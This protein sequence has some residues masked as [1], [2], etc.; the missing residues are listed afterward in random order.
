MTKGYYYGY[1]WSTGT[2]KGPFEGE[3]EDY[4][5]YNGKAYFRLTGLP[6][7][8][9]VYAKPGTI[10]VSRVYNVWLEEPDDKKAKEVIIKEL[11]KRRNMLKKQCELLE[12]SEKLLKDK[13]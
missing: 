7:R 12:K 9:R 6:V 13:L 2:F 3:L 4:V 1:E 8:Y 10:S 11:Q 5:T